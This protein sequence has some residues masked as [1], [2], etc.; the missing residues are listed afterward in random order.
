[1]AFYNLGLLY[2]PHLVCNTTCCLDGSLDAV[3]Q[4]G[5]KG[6][7]NRAEFE[8]ENRVEWKLEWNG[9]AKTSEMEREAEC[10]KKWN[11]NMEKGNMGYNRIGQ[12]LIGI[13][14]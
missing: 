14:A 12:C 1:M 2:D 7:G 11:G 8:M 3:G 6:D 4:K 10:G 9:K 5:E 13:Q